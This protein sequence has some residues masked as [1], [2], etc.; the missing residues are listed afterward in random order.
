MEK[1]LNDKC[2]ISQLEEVHNKLI[3]EIN[4][5]GSNGLNLSGNTNVTKEFLDVI[6]KKLGNIKSSDLF[7]ED[8]IIKSNNQR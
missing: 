6:M 1:N 8:R 2:A 3:D 4:K 7:K 5:G